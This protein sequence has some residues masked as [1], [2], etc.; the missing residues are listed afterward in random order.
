[1][2]E[3]DDVGLEVTK[4]YGGGDR[5]V[6][7][8]FRFAVRGDAE[9]GL[10]NSP[11]LTV[12]EPDGGTVLDFLDAARAMNY[13]AALRVLLGGAQWRSAEEQIERLHISEIVGMCQDIS[14]H[15]GLD[16]A[17]A[18]ESSRQNRRARRARR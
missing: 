9:V 2:A 12:H 16:L 15:F 11:V 5:T 14:Q 1:M 7:A 17:L 10:A 8:P 18:G 13:R 6:T 4:V 3:Q